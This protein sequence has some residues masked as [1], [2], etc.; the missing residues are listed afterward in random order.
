M[1]I[2]GVE[3]PILEEQVYVGVSICTVG[4]SIDKFIKAVNSNH[5]ANWS[6]LAT[7]HNGSIW[8]AFGENK[9]VVEGPTWYHGG[10]HQATLL[11]CLDS[12][13]V[14]STIWPQ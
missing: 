4:Y 10:N 14:R 9:G 13:P 12:L 6:S 2:F 1:Q 8:G 11:N 7:I 3:K 5:V